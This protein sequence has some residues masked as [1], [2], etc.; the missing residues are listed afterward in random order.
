M[1]AATIIIL[2]V[3]YEQTKAIEARK[4][5]I[6]KAISRYALCKSNSRQPMGTWR[7]NAINRNVDEAMFFVFRT[8]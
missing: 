6:A 4:G 8:R 3:K 1:R 2:R 5:A 7:N